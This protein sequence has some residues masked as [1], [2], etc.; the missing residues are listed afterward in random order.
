MMKILLSFVLT[1]LLA[2]CVNLHVYFPEAPDKPAEAAEPADP[3][4]PAAPAVPAAPP[5]AGAAP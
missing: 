5:P 3:A 1:A 4:D 2:G